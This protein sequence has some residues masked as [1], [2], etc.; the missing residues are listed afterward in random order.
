M[1]KLYALFLSLVMM[2][3]FAS[4]AMAADTATLKVVINGDVVAENVAVNVGES[5]YD[6]VDRWAKAP[7]NNYAIE[8]TGTTDDG[9][10]LKSLDGNG[11][12]PYIPKDLEEYEYYDSSIDD[13]ALARVNA[14]LLAKYPDSDGLGLWMGNGMGCSNDGPYMAYVGYDWTFTVNGSRPVDPNNTSLELYMNQTTIAA[15]DSIVLNYGET[16]EVWEY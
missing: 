16:I 7:E 4:T 15:G 10:I 14:A 2:F 12:L 13:P 11:S 6:A 3:A 9:L 8:W 5:V 1:K